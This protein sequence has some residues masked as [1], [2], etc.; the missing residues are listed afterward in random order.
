MSTDSAAPPLR[1][2]GAVNGITGLRLL[3]HGVPAQLVNISATGL[4]AESQAKLQVGSE[5][6][7]GFEGGFTPATAPGRVVRC[8]VAVMGR[9][10]L[11]RYHLGIE[12]DTPLP[13]E[14]AAD[15]TAAPAEPNVK[16]RW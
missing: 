12:F 1:R 3:P 11:L 6:T 9:D 15:Q 7:V 13:I 2:P 14:S 16:N 10:G 8:E 5:I 4:L